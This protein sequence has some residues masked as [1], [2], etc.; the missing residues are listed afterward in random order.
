M[1]QIFD[2]M[3]AFFNDELEWEV[4][5]IEDEAVLSMEFEG[6][7]GR[8]PCYAQAHEDQD[9]YVF[10]SVIPVTAPEGRRAAVS[11]LLTRVNYGML[12][13]NFELD[14]DDGEIR[15]KT[16]IDMEGLVPL[17]AEDRSVSKLLWKSL[18]YANVLVSDQY[19]PVI[20]SVIEG[21]AEPAEA[22]EQIEDSVTA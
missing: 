3:L 20:K 15:Y 2:A 7:N 11:E 9:R 21:H 16:S 8:W 19:L 6:D 22:L 17:S 1:G 5:E 12:I 18:V 14:M 4:S 13:G 10:Y